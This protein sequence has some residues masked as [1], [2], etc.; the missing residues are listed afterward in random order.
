MSTTTFVNV[1]IPQCSVLDPL[2]FN[3]CIN[4]I[5]NCTNKFDIVSYAD[6]TTLIST[7][8]SFTSLNTNISDNINSKLE[9]VN[10]YNNLV[11]INTRLSNLWLP[12]DLFYLIV[13]YV[14]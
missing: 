1:G 11:I 3:I 12:F 10:K 8:D 9:N 14:R 7:I 6:H 4:D 13:I 2:F 5:K